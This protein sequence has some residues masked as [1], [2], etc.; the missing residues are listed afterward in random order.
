MNWNY[1]EFKAYVLLEASHG[2]MVFSQDE[3]E[4]ITKELSKDTYKKIY[5]E[6]SKDADYERIQ[7]IIDAAKFHCDTADKK[8][9]LIDNVKGI[10]ESD[11]VFDQMEKNLLMFLKKLL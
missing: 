4:V 7:K 8:M 10:F 6:F 2:D 3:Q 1:D 11:G 5:D 9:E